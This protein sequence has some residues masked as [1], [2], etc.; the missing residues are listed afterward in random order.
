M[1]I[2]LSEEQVLKA[3]GAT[4]SRIGAR[5]SYAAICTDTRQI[6]PGCLFVALKGERFDAHEFLF[7]AAEGGAAALVVQKGRAVKLPGPDVAVYEVGD[8]LVALGKLAHFHRVRFKKPVGAVTG[9]NGKTTTKE[10]IAS[11]LATR[12][13]ALHTEGNLNNEIGVPLTLFNLEP[14]HVAAIIEMGMNHAGEISRLAAIAQPDAGLIT[15]VQP[16]HLEGV[17]SIEGVAAA[18]GE[19]F[20]GLK[21]GATAVVNLDD[22]RIVLQVKRIDPGVKTLTFGRT[23]GAQVHLTSVM[24]CGRDGLALVITFEGQPYPVALKLIGD[25]NALNATGAFA[26]AIALGYS[27]AECVR[28]LEAAHPHARRLQLLDGRNGVT[29]IDDCYNANPASMG[30]A[31]GTLTALS[32]GGRPVAVLG[33][34]LE[35]GST[36]AA[37]HDAVGTKAAEHAALIA[38]FGPRMQGAHAQAA[39]RLAANAQH[40]LELPALLQWLQSH[41]KAHDVVLVK[42]SRGMRLER[43]VEALTG[44]ASAGATH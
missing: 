24:A 37:E 5:A 38:F 30:A 16:A 6:V 32:A 10:L 21:P 13:P 43:V 12:G 28:G 15:I 27:P 41:L 42:G 17:G 20:A 35:L 40:F 19:L 44:T 34:M 1:S 2:R 8:T 23:A 22:A 29:V 36:E 26:L 7:Q 9:S 11:I 3:T 18:K 14:R 39:K 25:H 4:R 33:D 31:L